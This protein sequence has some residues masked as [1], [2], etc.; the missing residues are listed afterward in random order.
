MGHIIPFKTKKSL[1]VIK[2]YTWKL[3][4]NDSFNNKTK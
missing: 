1:F 2:G 4:K 3:H